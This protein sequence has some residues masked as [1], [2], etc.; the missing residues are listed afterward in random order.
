MMALYNLA[1]STLPLPPQLAFDTSFLLALR[2]DDDN[3]HSAIAQAF[4]RQIRPRI[5]AIEQVAWVVMP[6]LQECYHI[7][8]SSNLR[9]VWQTLPPSTR[10]ANWLTLYKKD[11]ATLKQGLPDLRRF[12]ELLAAIPL[13][14]ANPSD[15]IASASE[16]S[17][18]ERLR[19][20]IAHYQLLPQDALILAEAERIGV[21]AVVSLDSD[22]YRVAD[23][24]DVYTI[25]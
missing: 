22:W 18:E 4:V 9:R 3:P 24:L 6:V 2:P 8:L 16:S 1:D 25:L 5:A 17:L 7:I 14:I 11:P 12:D 20:F 19:Y 15:Q 23:E 13:T 10:P 21:R